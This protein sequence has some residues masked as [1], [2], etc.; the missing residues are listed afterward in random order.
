MGFV[1][2]VVFFV[3][4]SY[5]QGDAGVFGLVVAVEVLEGL[6]EALIVLLRELLLIPDGL[7]YLVVAVPHVLAELS[8]PVGDVV[9][10]D[11]VQVAVA[12]RVDN[13]GLLLDRQRVPLTLLQNGELPLSAGQGVLGS[14]VQVAAELGEAL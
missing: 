14:L 5:V 11:L 6:L 2:L 13:D 7:Q 9:G 8:L 12:D 3:S 1:F 4:G 10:L